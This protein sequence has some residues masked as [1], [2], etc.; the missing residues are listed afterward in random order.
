MW[1]SRIMET[2]T[3]ENK[4]NKNMEDCIFC[5]I[6]GKKID[7]KIVYEDKDVIAFNDTHPLAPIHVLVIPKK[8]IASINDIEEKDR[9]LMGKMVFAARNIAQDLGAAEGGYKLLLRVGKNG[10]QEVDHIHLH[11]IGGAALHEDIHPLKVDWK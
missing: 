9:L 4:K 6:A 11:L 10:G 1:L 2:H 7:A 8:H 3:A 5:K